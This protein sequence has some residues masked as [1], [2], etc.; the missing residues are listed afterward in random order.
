MT[1]TQS[2]K[3]HRPLTLKEL[4]DYSEFVKK[5]MPE[6]IYG[7]EMSDQ[8]FKKFQES[9]SVK[10]WKNNDQISRRPLSIYG[11][12]II[13]NPALDKGGKVHY[14][15]ESWKKVLKSCGKS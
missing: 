3:K 1:N 4:T 11:I 14:N 12:D 5:N 9:P 15:E 10:L 13:F 8:L 6:I 2:K 7:I